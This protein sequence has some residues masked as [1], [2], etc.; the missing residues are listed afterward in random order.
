MCYICCE[1]Y[2]ISVVVF[3]V[4]VVICYGVAFGSVY[5]IGKSIYTNTVVIPLSTNLLNSEGLGIKHVGI[6]PV[7]AK[8]TTVPYEPVKVPE[9]W[10]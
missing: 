6:C 1:E 10:I 9:V 7:K 8:P 2:E 5:P 4:F 3:S